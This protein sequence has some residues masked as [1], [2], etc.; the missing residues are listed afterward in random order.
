MLMHNML[1]HIIHMCLYALYESFL[2][3]NN[4]LFMYMSVSTLGPVNPCQSG[5]VY[6]ADRMKCITCMSEY[7][8][9]AIFV[10]AYIYIKDMHT[11]T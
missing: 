9:N 10:H 6:D 3:Y 1:M 7:A 5:Y 8:W 11:Y 4:N 2:N